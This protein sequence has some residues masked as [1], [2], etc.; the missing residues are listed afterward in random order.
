MKLSTKHTN[1]MSQIK[2]F[3]PDIDR[4]YTYGYTWLA[5]VIGT[6]TITVKDLDCPDNKPNVYP[7]V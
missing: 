3:D 6:S 2:P 5:Q 4:D 1:F 7:Y